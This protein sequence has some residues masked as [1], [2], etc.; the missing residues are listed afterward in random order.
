MNAKE[1]AAQLRGEI[2]IIKNQGVAAI[3]VDNLITYLSNVED[4]PSAEPSQAEIERYKADLTAH[5][6]ATKHNYNGQLEMFKSVIMAGQNAI[7][8]IVG[9]NGG[10]SVA[11]LAFLGHMAA[12]RSPF[13]PVYAA[14]LL[15]FAAGTLL[16]GL[17]SGGTYL[18]QWLYAGGSKKVETAGFV[19]NILVILFG[20]GSFAC[21]GLGAWW[22]YEAFLDTP[23][24]GTAPLVKTV[25]V[26]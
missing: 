6:E 23:P 11:M 1:F 7:R 15:P 4:V 19:V 5:I 18:S 26:G 10:A 9:I 13:I 24:Q 12:I 20:I 25:P 3:Y 8:T 2:E 17:I 22:T 16:G 21:F 14:C